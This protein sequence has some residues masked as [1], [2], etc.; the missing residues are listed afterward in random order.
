MN[1]RREIDGFNEQKKLGDKFQTKLS[2][3]STEATIETEN[4]LHRYE[5]NVDAESRT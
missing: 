4:Y 3:E 2:E 1:I 5:L